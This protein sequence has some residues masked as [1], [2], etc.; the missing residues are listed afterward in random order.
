MVTCHVD[1]SPDYLSVAREEAE[2]RGHASRVTFVR[3]D[4]AELAPTQ[5][6]S[7]VVTLDR[8]ICCYPDMERLVALA[9]GKSGRLL[10]AVYPRAVWWMRLAVRGIN[11][12]NWIRRS[13]FRTYLHAP[14]AIDAI[15]RA[16]GLER[17][18]FERTVG[19]E[20]AVYAR[21]AET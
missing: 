18:S 4:F 17:R 5:N 11:A 15:V 3:G 19:W 21:A 7:D 2:R 10:G 20:V 16:Q 12:F 1:V 6:E 8:V 13:A 14:A 9:A